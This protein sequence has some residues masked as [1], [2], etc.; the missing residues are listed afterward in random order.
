[1]AEKTPIIVGGGGLP[2]GKPTAT[3][4]PTK[5]LL[6]T[7]PHNP[8]AKKSP[9]KRPTPTPL[10]LQ[11][12]YANN[13]QQRKPKHVAVSSITAR[14][15]SSSSQPDHPPTHL[16]PHPP[17]R[18]EAE[19]NDTASSWNSATVNPGPDR[20][21]KWVAAASCCRQSACSDARTACATAS[22]TTPLRLPQAFSAAQSAPQLTRSTHSGGGERGPLSSSIAGRVDP[23]LSSAKRPLDFSR[24]L[25]NPYKK[26]TSGA[27]VREVSCREALEE[28]FGEDNLCF[29]VSFSIFKCD[30]E[31][32]MYDLTTKHHLNQLC[33]L[34]HRPQ[35]NAK[36]AIQLSSQSIIDVSL[37]ENNWLLSL[38][39]L[40]Q[41]ELSR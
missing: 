4:S 12:P 34:F 7:L 14:S 21:T 24:C 31:R 9:H 11:N 10:P 29:M 2:Q 20:Y 26:S 39:F 23:Q 41:F 27:H 15:S 8:Y 22:A 19:A 13:S 6:R 33:V 5:R 3:T 28:D 30:T 35:I 16:S 1:M 36:H 17:R 40:V 37:D 18:N 38:P 32:L 25:P